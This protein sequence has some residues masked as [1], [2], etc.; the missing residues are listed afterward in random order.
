MKCEHSFI[1]D[2]DTGKLTGR[3]YCLKCGKE[4]IDK[5]YALCRRV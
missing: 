3:M 5:D 2:C 4:K 1:Y